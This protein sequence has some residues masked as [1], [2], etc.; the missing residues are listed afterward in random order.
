MKNFFKHLHTVNKH[1]FLVFIYCFKVG[2]PIRGLI[3]DLSKYSKEEFFESVKYYSGTHSPIT[4][5]KKD[6]GYSLAWLHHRG[7]NKHHFEYWYDENAP[8]S[9]PIIPYKYAAE[10]VCDSLAA[11]KTYNGKNWTNLSQV[12]YWKNVRARKDLRINPKIVDF[13]TEMYEIISKEGI[14]KGLTRKNMKE[15]YAKNCLN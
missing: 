8:D 5:A 10:I 14:K 13:C 15:V 9:T 2:L 3:H 7:R 6:K 12:N 4:E 11:S 1:R